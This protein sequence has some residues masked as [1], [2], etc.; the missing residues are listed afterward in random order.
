MR[1]KYA[2]EARPELKNHFAVVVVVVVVVVV[3][4][5]RNV[6]CQSCIAL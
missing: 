4:V 5:V 6:I 2:T 3:G 1:L